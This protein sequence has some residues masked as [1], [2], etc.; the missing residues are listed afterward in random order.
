LPRAALATGAAM[1]L[2]VG[3]ANPE[4]WIARQNIER[5]EETGKVDLDYLA[6][7]GPDAT[8]VI[9]EGLPADLAQDVIGRQHVPSPDDWLGWN[10]GR[11]RAA[12]VAGW[13][14]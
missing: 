8:P 10:L 13:G 12:Q 4:A 9:A 1:V 6:T 11:A 14:G 3:V 7:L 2:L 5:Y